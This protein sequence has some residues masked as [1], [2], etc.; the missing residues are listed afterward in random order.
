MTRRNKDFLL[1][2]KVGKNLEATRSPRFSN[3]FLVRCKYTMESLSLFLRYVS[4]GR[5]REREREKE[6][7]GIFVTGERDLK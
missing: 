4:E 5:E 7:F 3:D 2:G 6:S 1:F